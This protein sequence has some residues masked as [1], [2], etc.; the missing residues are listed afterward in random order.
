MPTHGLLRISSIFTVSLT[1]VI[2]GEAGDSKT[3]PLG[4]AAEHALRQSQVTQPGSS[5][6]HLRAKIVETTNPDSAY[7]GDIE[8]TWISP[9]KWRRTVSSPNFSQTLI[10]NGDEQFEHDTGDYYPSWLH[11]LVEAMFDPLPMLEQLK[12]VNSQIAKPSGSE[13]SESCARLVMKVGIA[14]VQNSAFAVFCFEGSKG[15]VTTV[16]TP[17]CSAVFK[18]YKPFNTKLVARRLVSDPEPGTTIEE[19][20]TQLSELTK[21]DESLFTVERPT[22]PSEWLNIVQIDEATARKLALNTPDIQWPT[23]TSGKTSGV[24]SLFVSVDRSGRVR[25]VWPLN[26][27]NPNLNDSARKQVMKWLF[28]SATVD[29]TPAQFET[30]LTFSFQTKAR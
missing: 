10:R 17:L 4:E 22:L 11:N 12:Q 15:L 3:V 18:D 2:G 14:P 24:L 23:V 26:S 30:I 19:S 9:M 16:S 27:D 7:K 8:E 1:L 13:K 20:I 5:S 28:Q 21:A 29:G 6:F 25:E